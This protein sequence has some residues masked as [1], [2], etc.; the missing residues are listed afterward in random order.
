MCC[1]SDLGCTPHAYTDTLAAGT[2]GGGVIMW[3]WRPSLGAGGGVGGGG[4]GGKKHD[5]LADN[6]ELLATATLAGPLFQVKVS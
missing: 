4:E 1:K 2:S 5:S 3:T 6:W